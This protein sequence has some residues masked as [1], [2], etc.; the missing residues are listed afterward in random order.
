[1]LKIA[2]ERWVANHVRFNRTD[3]TKNE[4]HL[5]VGS[6][7]WKVEQGGRRD[8]GRREG[9]SRIEEPKRVIQGT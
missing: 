6:G 5:V 1:M 4:T 3:Y 9:G 7:K 2:Q 8:G